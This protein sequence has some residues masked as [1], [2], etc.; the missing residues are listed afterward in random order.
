MQNVIT[1]RQLLL[2]EKYVAHGKNTKKGPQGA[3][4]GPKFIYPKSYFFCDLELHAKFQNPSTTPSGR[5]V[6]G[7]ERKKKRK[8]NNPKNSGHFVPQ[9][10]LR[11]A[12]ALCSDQYALK[13]NIV[14]QKIQRFT[15]F[16]KEKNV[17]HA[18]HV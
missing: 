15:R 7:T 4:G 2:G 13:G 17:Q 16:I 5:K 12:H 18:F 10:R 8:K 9:Q 1:L 6:W 3:T 11:A 14:E